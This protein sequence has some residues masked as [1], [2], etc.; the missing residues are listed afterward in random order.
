[1]WGGRGGLRGQGVRVEMGLLW[2]ERMWGGLR[3]SMEVH[4]AAVC[5]VGGVMLG[6][7]RGCG[8]GHGEGGDGRG[9]DPLNWGSME[10]GGF[11]AWGGGLGVLGCIWGF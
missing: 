10:R 1:M 4:R 5:G 7:A 6:G 2:G 8:R 9:W 3:G 11:S